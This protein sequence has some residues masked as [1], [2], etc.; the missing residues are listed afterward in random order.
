MFS[1][2]NI[3]IVIVVGIV[4]LLLFSMFFSRP[5]I[6][7]FP[8]K[9]GPIIAFGDSLVE[10]VGTTPGNTF[11]DNLSERIGEP[12]LNMG[13]SGDTTEDGVNRMQYVLDTKPRIVILLLGGNDALK[14][15]PPEDTFKNVRTII[16]TFQN[17][18]IA[19][20]LIAPPGGISYANRY[21]NEYE[22]LAKE[23]GVAYVPN[24][25]K[26]LLG[27]SEYMADIIHPNNEGHKIMADKIEPVLKVLLENRIK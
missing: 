23:Y 11:V 25:L 9:E 10:G 19:V 17:E 6:T 14:R 24:I 15:V 16:S 12:I 21:E 22:T 18:G 26:G 1:L 2:K 20:L 5:E 4:F 7:N 13:V 3:F 27:K 8:T